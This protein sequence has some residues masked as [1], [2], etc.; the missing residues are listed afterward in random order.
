MLL[1]AVFIGNLP[2]KSWVNL[3]IMLDSVFFFTAGCGDRYHESFYLC[4][5]LWMAFFCVVLI[6]A[7]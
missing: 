4:R 2:C 6:V 1:K 5:N 7:K 3:V